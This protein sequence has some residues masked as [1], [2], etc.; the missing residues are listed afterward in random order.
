MPRRSMAAHRMQPLL[1]VLLAAL[2]LTLGSGVGLPGLVRAMT[3]ASSHVCTCA[4]GGT[5]SSCPVC[6][7][8]LP[9]R[10]SLV[11]AIEGVPCGERPNALG[12]SCEPALASVA[13]NL[14]PVPFTYSTAWTDGLPTPD[15][16]FLE[17]AT[18]PP[19]QPS[20]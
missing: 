7:A 11:L 17:R 15:A 2:M 5:H 1:G 16:V 9:N 4:S 8:S 10:G 6:N 14:L 20:A 12:A 18:P 3:T 19:R 13:R